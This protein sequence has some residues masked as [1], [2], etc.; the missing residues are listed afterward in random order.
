MDTKNSMPIWTTSI[1]PD[2]EDDAV[3]DFRAG[4]HENIGTCRSV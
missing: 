1:A 3:G 4:A 2:A